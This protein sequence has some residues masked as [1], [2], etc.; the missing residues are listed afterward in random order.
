[1]LEE[2]KRFVRFKNIVVVLSFIR[3]HVVPASKVKAG[4]TKNSGA[5]SAQVK[6]RK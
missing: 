4:N 3:V 6:T 5:L 1:M 2:L